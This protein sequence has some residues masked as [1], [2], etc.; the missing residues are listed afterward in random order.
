VFGLGNHRGHLVDQHRVRLQKLLARHQLGRGLV[1]RQIRK[2]FF[3]QIERDA[4][5]DRLALGARNI[6]GFAHAV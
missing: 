5:D 4:E 6:K 1:V 3:L 2:F